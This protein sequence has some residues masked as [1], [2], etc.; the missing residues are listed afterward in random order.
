MAGVS[1]GA[2]GRSL[3]VL[4]DAGASGAMGDAQLV[5]RV[6]S[7]RAEA[8]G[9]AFEA[10]VARHGPM[11]LAVCR[12]ALDDPHAAEDAFQATF[13]VLARRAGSIR[14]G[15]ALASWLF[16]VARRV[17][18]RARVAD[19]RRRRHERRA[20]ERAETSALLAE[21]PD[22]AA[23]HEEIGRL[24][25]RYRLP[26]ILC[27]LEGLTYEAAADRLACPL[28]TLSTRL[29][30]ARSQ[31]KT[32]LVRRGLTASVAGFAATTAVPEALAADAAR[33]ARGVLG[34][35]A[36]G[37]GMVPEPV[38]GLVEGVIQAMK[39]QAKRKAIATLGLGLGLAAIVGAGAAWGRAGDGDKPKAEAR[40]VMPFHKVDVGA[41][42]LIGATGLNIYKF[43]LEMPKGQKFRVVLRVLEA[44]DKPPRVLYTF[45]F[46]K[47]DEGPMTILTS[48]LRRDGKLGG[49]LLSQ[50]EL[51]EFRVETP[52]CNPSGI[53]SFVSVPLADVEPTR[54]MLQVHRSDKQLVEDGVKETRL[55]TL[56]T[57]EPDKGGPGPTSYPR[58]E[59]LIERE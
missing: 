4:F 24:P 50:E 9:P 57:R 11:V 49:V 17:S 5:E 22:F 29:N 1:G 56:T 43:K 14:R 47:Q 31:L 41:E 26:V 59:F 13:L 10:I 42:E 21:R 3:G 15:E 2:L 27:D 37:L 19:A 25:E 54:K 6:V 36:A 16:G 52:G 34:N 12:R 40:D 28:G 33:L 35:P 45:P 32:R 53:A 8:S 20:A 44:Q 7:G 39:T 58:G 30:R 51:A 38:A 23:L 48:F 18:D 55:L 46:T